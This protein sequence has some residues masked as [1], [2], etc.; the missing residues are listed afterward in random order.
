MQANPSPR[1]QVFIVEDSVPIRER[2]AGL[3]AAI[4]GV[5]VV[6]EADTQ[7]AA[8][9]GILRTH[10]DSVVLDIQLPGGSGI[11][12]LRKVRAQCPDTAFIVLTNYPNPQY[13]RACIEAGASCFLDKNTDF[14]K[15]G[16][17]VAGLSAGH[18]QE[19]TPQSTTG[20]TS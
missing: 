16:E 7:G 12:V 15:V 6:G 14:S 8:I 11:E 20:R 10:P 9:E 13:R 19:K 2:L 4:E 18:H 5:S 1:V 3:L 17:A